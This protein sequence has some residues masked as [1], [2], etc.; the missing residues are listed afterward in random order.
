[1]QTITQA[2]FGGKISKILSKPVNGE[3]G[4]PESIKSTPTVKRINKYELELTYMK[5]PLIFNSINKIVQTIMSASYH[6]VCKDEKV[7][8]YF[9]NFIE[10]LGKSGTDITWEE[11]LSQI[12]K[13]Q[14]IYGD[15]WIENVYNKKG[16]KIVDWDIINANTM[17]YAKDGEGNILLDDM[18]RVLGYTQTLPANVRISENILKRSIAKKPKLCVLPDN[19]IFIEKDRVAQ[20]KL[21]CIGDGFYPVGLIAPIYQTSLRKM[22]MEYALSN[23]IYKHGFPIV[24]ASLGDLNHE[25]TPQQIQSMLEKLK[26]I[27]FKQEIATPYYYDLKILE[28][29]RTTSLRENLEYFK[30]A[31]ITGLGIPETYATG[32]GGDTNRAVLDSQAALFQLTLRDIIE[33]TTSAIRRYMFAPICKLEG[34]DEVPKLDWDIIGIDEVEKKAGRIVS[35]VKEGILAPDEK[36]KKLITEIEH[37]GPDFDLPPIEKGDT[38]KEEK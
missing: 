23:A 28:S 36:L 33:K 24:H 12:F 18:G 7:K 32:V 14:C 16:N 19:A 17:D 31:E 11:L 1:M 22:N 27:N 13:D 37:L 38:E 35:Y 3:T 21:Y 9:E 26:N 2:L 25:P 34:F 6:L 29:S 15:A 4:E 5:N 20:L 30:E 8:E 10:E